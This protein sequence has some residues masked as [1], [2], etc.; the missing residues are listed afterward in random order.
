[1]LDQKHSSPFPDNT[2]APEPGFFSTIQGIQLGLILLV[3]IPIL[4]ADTIL[5]YNRYQRKKVDVVESN[6]EMARAVAHAFD[7]YIQDVSS[8]ELAIG[9]SLLIRR[10]LSNRQITGILEAN[11]KAYPS[12]RNF[13]WLN[14]KG[15]VIASSLPQ[16]VGQDVSDRPAYKELLASNKDRS[17]SSLYPSQITG[18]PIFTIS[19]AIRS[20]TGEILGI[21]TAVV[22]IDSMDRQFAI[23]RSKNS[24]L[25]IID[26]RG[27]LVYRYPNVSVSWED[28]NWLKQSPSFYQAVLSGKEV[29]RSIPSIVK[30]ELKITAAV[31]ISSIGWAASAGRMR[32]D[33]LVPIYRDI[34]VS[35][36]IIFLIALVSF[37]IALKWSRKISDNV[38]SL[39][40]HA[41]ALGR[42]EY[43]Y[44]V[45]ISGPRELRDLA[46]VFNRMSD[47]IVSRESDRIAHL[48]RIHAELAARKQA[49]AAL[50]ESEDR[51]HHLVA[52][53]PA[54]VYTC[55][56][57]GLLTYYN[58]QAVELWGRAPRLEDRFCGSYRLYTTGGRRLSLEETPLVLAVR[59][60]TST[61]NAEFTME[62]PDGSRIIVSLNADP[63]YSHAGDPTGAIAVFM[64]ITDRKRAEEALRQSEE[65]LRLALSA[66]SLG[67][68]EWDMSTGATVFENERMFEIFG[69][70]RAD[71][72]IT[73]A[74]ITDSVTPE[75]RESFEAELKAAMRSDG[76]AH[77]VYRILRLN[78]RLLRWVEG[79][80]QLD[81]NPDGT[82]RRLVGVVADITDKRKMEA[83]LLQSRAELEIHVQERTAEL[84]LANQ[85]LDRQREVL[86]SIVDN[87]PVMLYLYDTAG[88]MQFASR[89]MEKVLG[90]S[91]MEM[92]NSGGKNL[93]NFYPDPAY[94]KMV[95]HQ[96]DNPS[97]GWRDFTMTTKSGK[98][99][100]T[101]WAIVSLSDDSRVCIGIDITERKAIE[102]QLRL[103]TRR[104]IQS[105]QSLQEFAFIA[106]HDLQEPLRKVMTFGRMLRQQHAGRMDKEGLDYL[107]RMINASERMQDL[108][109]SLLNYSRVT[110]KIEPFKAVDLGEIVR[111]VLSDLEVSLDK[112]H[113]KVNVGKLPVISADPSQIRQLFQNLIGN[114]LKF[115]R[116][117]ENPV[118]RINSHT[119]ANGIRIDVEDNGT[120]FDEAYAD[121]IFAP[122]TRLHS[123]VEYEGTGM[124]L[125]I[126]KKIVERHGGTLSVKSTPGKGSVF[127]VLLPIHQAEEA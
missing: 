71:G 15:K 5:F 47:E 60:K 23:K 80:G 73:M 111:E 127:S 52:I 68:F 45:G 39:Q 93:R 30:T 101:S 96:M 98:Q 72:P 61:R 35:F 38:G 42:G 59:E 94:R 100:D 53:L 83:E 119:V 29:V 116:P 105:N 10:D 67:V 122:F 78:D 43:Q 46:L 50:L 26:N 70:T 13:S 74:N 36:G 112:T 44:K 91:T 20:N 126:C 115:H 92:K 117:E 81:F 109:K 106:S 25:N 86:Q 56:A 125:A 113:G 114:A 110:T 77:M 123:R 54:A 12:V 6:V 108:L 3:L 55:N 124:G 79:F 14:P 97:G 104:L 34:L 41:L 69:R 120:G 65:R 75:D 95:R 121:K 40:K 33:V 88:G 32:H 57:E 8:R 90:W 66:A 102:K 24:I 58:Q 118:V 4:L 76:A 2:D 103:F 89:A 87:I 31:P 82:A 18:E 84:T 63:L 37:F 85:M 1:M 22:D 19:R 9:I 11:R 49:E 48:S 107:D 17:V 64:D 28:R 21:V 62:R 7:M 51:Y 99:I 27:M 16:L